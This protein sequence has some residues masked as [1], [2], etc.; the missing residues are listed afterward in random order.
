MQ[1]QEPAMLRCYR[2]NDQKGWE[3]LSLD[4]FCSAMT[5]VFLHRGRVRIALCGQHHFL[6]YVRF[7][8]IE[9][10]ADDWVGTGVCT[11]LSSL[12]CYDWLSIS[13]VLSIRVHY[14]HDQILLFCPLLAN[15]SSCGLRY[16]IQTSWYDI[17]L[18]YDW[19]LNKKNLGGFFCM[20]L[21]RRGS[22]AICSLCLGFLLTQGRLVQILR[23]S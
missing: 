1:L 16:W 19:A 3:S 5:F 13:V 21:N 2:L 10:L 15:S 20:F 4:R 17:F 14:F 11:H 12:C 23:K 7:A 18:F 9:S 8:K 22:G 6:F